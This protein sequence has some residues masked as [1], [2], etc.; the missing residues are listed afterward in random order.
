MADNTNTNPSANRPFGPGAPINGASR[1]ALAAAA[2]SVAT[3]TKKDLKS[4]QEVRWC[5]GCGD[6]AILNMVQTVMAGLGIPKEQMVFVSV[7]I[8]P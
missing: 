7:I 5:P 4:D 8:T 6:Y 2:A 1:S 3:L